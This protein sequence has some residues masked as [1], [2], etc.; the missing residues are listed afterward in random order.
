[1]ITINS[2][3]LILF[4]IPAFFVERDVMR[5]LHRFRLQTSDGMSPNLDTDEPYLKGAKEVFQEDNK[6]VVFIFGHTHAAFLRRLGP[7][8]QVVIN[9]GTV[10][11]AVIPCTGAFRLVAR[12]L[13]CFLSLEL[14]SHRAGKTTSL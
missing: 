5:T 13:L 9:T 6:V 1:M 8:G 11:E 2:I 4:G 7:T 14:L 10:A 12:N 3:F